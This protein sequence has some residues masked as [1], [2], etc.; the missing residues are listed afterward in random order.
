MPRSLMKP[1]MRTFVRH[2]AR[3]CHLAS[4]AVVA[5]AC[6]LA[7]G[8]RADAAGYSGLAHPC[9]YTFGAGSYQDVSYDGPTSCSEA[10]VLIVDVTRDGARRPKL[11]TR[12]GHTTHG[13]W[14]CLTVRRREAHGV[15]V[16]TH[17]ITCSLVDDPLDR[18]ARVRFF[19]EG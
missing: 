3:T 1:T 14:R 19:Y 8:A 13:T 9:K 10:H 15:I 4:A 6:A 5:L 16:S 2:S 7:F 17:R 18:V 11:G 12:V